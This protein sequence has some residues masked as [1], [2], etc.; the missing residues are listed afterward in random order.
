MHSVSTFSQIL[1]AS[2]RCWHERDVD[3]FVLSLAIPIKLIDPLIQLPVI[4]R[5]EQF[6]FLWDC[7]PSLCIAAAGQCQHFDLGGQQRFDLA[8]RF[9]DETF[10]RLID[11]APNGPNHAKPRVLLAF[12]FFEQIAK[13]DTDIGGKTT[14]QAVLPRWQLTSENQLA[15]L[16]L[17]AVVSHESDAREIAEHLWLMRDNLCNSILDHSGQIFDKDLVHSMGNNWC[18]SYRPSLSRG[19]ELVN[20]GEL[21]KLVLAVRQSIVLEKPFDPLFMLAKLRHHQEASCRF[22]WRTNKEQS[23]FGASPERLLSV[24]S[25]QVRSDALAGTANKNSQSIDLLRSEKNLRE[26]ALV[27]SSIV[28]QLVDFGLEPESPRAPELFKQGDLIHIHTPIFAKAKDR[29]PLHLLGALHPTPAVAGLPRRNALNWLRALEPF[30]RG[31]YAAPIGWVDIN[32][33][34]DFRVAIRCGYS[35]GNQLDLIAGAGLVKGSSIEGEMQE[36][37]LKFAV[38]ANQLNLGNGAY[39]NI[40]KRCSIT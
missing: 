18:N 36:V 23:F 10:S 16:R 27:V 26:H 40:F 17:N 31:C 21:K 6:S 22:L 30:E 19:I 7:M 35:R 28:E 13:Q 25:G 38:L 14:L 29:L 3:E 12:S 32:G 9:C 15:W 1:T 39:S 34:A 33:N 37:A 8:Q 2:T 20:S 5:H 11:A 4:A 24:K